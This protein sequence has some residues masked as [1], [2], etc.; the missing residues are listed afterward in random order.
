NVD[1]Y[2]FDLNSW[3]NLRILEFPS[4][5]I[6]VAQ[7]GLTTSNR[8]WDEHPLRELRITNVKSNNEAWDSIH[9]LNL[10]L[11]DAIVSFGLGSLSLVEFSLD[12]SHSSESA[13]KKILEHTTELRKLGVTI[14]INGPHMPPY[15]AH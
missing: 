14:N 6:A 5:Y 4:A 12:H 1:I 3:R 13:Q 15:W 7:R 11:A 8:Q 2:Y 9:A 10:S